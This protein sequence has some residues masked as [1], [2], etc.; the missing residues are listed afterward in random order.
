MNELKPGIKTTEFLI[1]IVL[2][3]VSVLALSGLITKNEAMQA[4]SF[5]FAIL[6][7][8]GYS[9]SRIYLKAKQFEKIIDDI[10][11]KNKE[12]NNN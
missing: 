10:P 11:D 5:V 1:V 8:L 2:I 6:A 4:I 7:A 9:T 3:V 12:N